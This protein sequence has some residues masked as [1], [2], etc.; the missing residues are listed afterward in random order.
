MP[1]AEHVIVVEMPLAEHVIVV[2]MP[3]ADHVIV[4]ETPLA[5]QVLLERG[6]LALLSIYTTA[7]CCIAGRHVQSIKL[8]NN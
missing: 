4:V 6:L 8:M 2:E 7:C 1:L 5:R 3:L